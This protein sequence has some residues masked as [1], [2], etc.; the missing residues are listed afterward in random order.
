M[1]NR[2]KK[3]DREGGWLRQLISSLGPGLIIAATVFGAGSII[4]ASKAGASAG[5]SYLWVLALAAV[6][7]ITF[8][9]IA[10]KI[11]CVGEK[12]MLGHIEDNYSRG[13]AVLFG[14]CCSLIC[15]GF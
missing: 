9:K 11:G 15:T 14:L 3:T 12:S 2:D 6:F 4:T 1:G 5:Y 8:T 13:M 10:A 7:M